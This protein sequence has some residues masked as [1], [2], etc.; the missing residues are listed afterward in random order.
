MATPTAIGTNTKPLRLSDVATDAT[1]PGNW[2]WYFAGFVSERWMQG[3]IGAYNTGGD[4]SGATTFEQM[5]WTSVIRNVK[6]KTKADFDK[7]KIA[8]A[9]WNAD[10]A[11][12]YWQ[13][14][15]A[16]VDNA[17]WVNAAFNAVDEKIRVKIVGYHWREMKTGGYVG[18]IYLLRVTDV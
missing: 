6:I 8:F 9:R 14:K 1:D 18:D 5:E 3:L 2:V 11:D 4:L 16:G 10:D 17:F 12:L 7:I 13:N 15:I